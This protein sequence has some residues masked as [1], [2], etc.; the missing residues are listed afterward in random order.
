MHD[1]GAV[2]VGCSAGHIEQSRPWLFLSRI[3][4]VAAFTLRRKPKRRS[5]IAALHICGY[6]VPLYSSEVVLASD[7]RAFA[8]IVRVLAFLFPFV[9]VRPASISSVLRHQ[10]THDRDAR[11]VG[12]G[13][14]LVAGVGDQARAVLLQRQPGQNSLLEDLHI[15]IGKPQVG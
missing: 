4:S 10:I 11:F 12:A 2:A 8:T 3:V 15:H 5:P 7:R 14:R 1:A 9:S 6:W 13:R